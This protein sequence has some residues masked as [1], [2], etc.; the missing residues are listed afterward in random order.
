MSTALGF[1]RIDTRGSEGALFQQVHDRCAAWLAGA[2]VTRENAPMYL[3]ALYSFCVQ[4]CE[5]LFHYAR[6]YPRSQ[7]TDVLRTPTAAMLYIYSLLVAILQAQALRGRAP[8]PD[9][10]RADAALARRPFCAPPL[11]A[12]PQRGDVKIRDGH[13]RQRHESASGGTGADYM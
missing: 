10:P 8:M 4:E 12:Q 2:H 13:K 11:Q 9:R 1:P 7:L 5:P 3:D 6:S